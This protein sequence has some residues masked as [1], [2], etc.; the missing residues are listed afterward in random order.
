M[1][2][3]TSGVIPPSH[4]INTMPHQS[5]N[6]FNSTK[7]IYKM[8]F[9]ANQMSIYDKDPTLRTLRGFG[10]VSVDTF[11]D[12]LRLQKLAYLIQEIGRYNS[13][14]HS[15]YIRGPYSPSLTS[16]LYLGDEVDVFKETP[17]LS[18][19]DHTLINQINELLDG[20]S[21]DPKYLE[22][23][24]SVWFLMPNKKIS[25]ANEQLVLDVMQQEKPHFSI[26]QVKNTIKKIDQ[27]K[28]T[29]NLLN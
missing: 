18:D 5:L 3:K 23:F 8:A 14:A 28:Q 21:N 26:E 22:L 24:A 25:P 15:W 6:S 27:F 13:V 1:A 29:H 17:Q 4:R 10:N 7:S 12:R 11:N 16:M 2:P 19:N 9:Y 20:K